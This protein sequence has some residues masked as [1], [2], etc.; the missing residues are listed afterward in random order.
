MGTYPF[1][2]KFHSGVQAQTQNGTLEETIS[3]VGISFDYNIWEDINKETYVFVDRTSNIFLGIDQRYEIGG[4]FI[5]SRHSGKN[6]T[7]KTSSNKILKKGLTQIQK[8]SF[9]ESKN[10][11]ID[12]TSFTKINNYIKEKVSTDYK[13]EIDRLAS[14]KDNLI[15]RNQKKY[16]TTRLSILFG[17]NYELEKTNDNLRIFQRDTSVIDSFPATN[18]FRLVA[19]PGFEW[20]GSN[21]S[22]DT[23]V[24]F[25]LGVF[26]ETEN[27]I[28]ESTLSDRRIDYW[29][30]WN[31]NLTFEFTKKISLGISYTYFYDNAPNRSFINQPENGEDNFNIFSAEDTFQAITFKFGYKL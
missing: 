4:G 15:K 17:L 1:Q 9:S 12:E 8:L 7:V 11:I 19:R 13:K 20:Q 10:Q 27:T 31:N 24:Y 23:K 6:S 26:G 14:T 25:K 18:I 22:F 21:F 16:S 29:L 30:E 28:T 2:F 5:F 3:D